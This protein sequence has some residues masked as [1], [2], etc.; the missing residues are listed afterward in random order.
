MWEEEGYRVRSKHRVAGELRLRGRDGGAAFLKKRRR[1][2]RKSE[3]D[4]RIEVYEG[5]KIEISQVRGPEYT[6]NVESHS[7]R[8]REKR[9]LSLAENGELFRRKQIGFLFPVRQKTNF[10]S[11]SYG[12]SA[13]TRGE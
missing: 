12:G 3:R 2:R 11:Q 7:L 10:M 13:R 5:M 9:M 6:E 4:G 8:G 1:K